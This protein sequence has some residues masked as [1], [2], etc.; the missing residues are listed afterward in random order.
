MKQSRVIARH[1][2]PDSQLSVRRKKADVVKIFSGPSRTLADLFADFFPNVNAHEVEKTRL[3]TRRSQDVT[4]GP[5]SNVFWIA[6]SEILGRNCSSF[7]DFTFLNR[8]PLF[9]AI[10]LN[11]DDHF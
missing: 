6:C 4:R 8:F 1:V 10:F 3:N 5:K 9:P 7:M 2:C 11:V